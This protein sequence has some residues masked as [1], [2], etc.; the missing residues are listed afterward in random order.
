[1]NN[2]IKKHKFCEICVSSSSFL[3][4]KQ[5]KI[6]NI[7]NAFFLSEQNSLVTSYILFIKLKMCNNEGGKE[8][9]TV[10]F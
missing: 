4:Y 9:N 7:K 5:N 1:M 3:T 2:I 8:I 6:F 10:Q